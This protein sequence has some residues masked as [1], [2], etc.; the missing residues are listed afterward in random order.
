MEKHAHQSLENKADKKGEPTPW[1]NSRARQDE[2][3]NEDVN[4]MSLSFSVNIVK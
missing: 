2:R 4:Y 3:Y 1:Y